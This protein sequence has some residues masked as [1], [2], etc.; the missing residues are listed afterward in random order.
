MS[1]FNINK[2]KSIIRDSENIVIFDIGAH[3]FMD[4]ITLKMAYPNST[5]YAFEPDNKNIQKYSPLAKNYG[6]NVVELALSD[7]IGETTFYN[8]ESLNGSEWTCSGSILKPVTIDGTSEGVHHKGLLYNLTGYK[9]KTT[10]FKDFCDTHNIVPNI[11]H[12]DV[13]G[14]ETKVIKGMGN[15]R[16]K[17]IFAETCEFDTY[18]T[19]TSLQ[20]FDELMKSLNYEIVERLEYDTFYIHTS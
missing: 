4:S 8:S 3:N 18:E 11:I 6:V 14:A 9:V 20:Q 17:V 10:T 13:Q 16:P 1:S 5:V 15:Y 19:N 12:M 7:E 2:A